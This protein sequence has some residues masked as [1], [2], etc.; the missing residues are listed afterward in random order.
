MQ[1]YL[2]PGDYSIQIR[3]EIATLLSENK[4]N[5]MAMAENARVSY[6]RG[7]F[8]RRYDVTKIFR[9][10]AEFDPERTYAPAA[11]ADDSELVFY[12]PAAGTPDA[13]KIYRPVVPTDAGESPETDAEKWEE[14]TGRNPFVVLKLIDLINYDLHSKYARRAMPETVRERYREAKDW[15]TRVGDGLIDADLPVL[16]TET[17]ATSGDIRYNSHEAEDNRW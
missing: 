17:E 13:Y 4:E 2:H 14:Y 12:K 6:M 8:A 5:I 10:M 3:N 15:V 7:E 1:R 16:D 11:I 9:L